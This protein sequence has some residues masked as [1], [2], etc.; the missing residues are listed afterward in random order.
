MTAEQEEAVKAT[1]AQVIADE[2]AIIAAKKKAKKD[3]K[4]ATVAANMPLVVPV[5]ETVVAEPKVET[6]GTTTT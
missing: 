5:V 1:I 2:K 4:E 6:G 3:A